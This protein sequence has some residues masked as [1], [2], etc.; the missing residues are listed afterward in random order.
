SLTFSPDGRLLVALLGGAKET[1]I[2]TIDMQTGKH[3]PEQHAVFP[4]DSLAALETTSSY[5]GPK[6]RCLPNQAGYFVD[7]EV[8]IDGKTRRNVW[9]LTSEPDTFNHALRLPVPN[10]FVAC[11]GAT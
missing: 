7:G 6:I 2:D 10:G 11:E 1:R 5:K 9:R 3:E 8:W 4:G